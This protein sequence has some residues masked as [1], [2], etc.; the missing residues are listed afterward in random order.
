MNTAGQPLLEALVEQ[1]HYRCPCCRRPDA[2]ETSAVA[3]RPHGN[4]YA[5]VALK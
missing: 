3:F 4:R 2:A 5:M 1:G